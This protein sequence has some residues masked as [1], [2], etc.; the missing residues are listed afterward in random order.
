MHATHISPFSGTWY[1][2]SAAELELLLEECRAASAVR[3]GPYL[4]RDALGYV[5]PHAGP[6]YSGTV[7]SAV[8][9]SLL[10][11]NPERIV[12][13]AFTHRGGLHGIASPEVQRISTPLGEVA[14]DGNFAGGFPLVPESRLC[15]H[16]FEIQLPF[17]Q[18]AA[19]RSLLT[20]L[21]VGPMDAA[22]RRAAAERIASAW[23]PG[24][25]F[26]A[27]SDFTHYGRSFGYVP[28]PSNHSVAG[29]LHELDHDCIAAAGSLDSSLFL[30]T[31]NA[32][33]ATVCGTGPIALLL[34]VLRNL[35]NRA[36]YQFILDYQ[37]SGEITGDYRH[38]VSYA[39]LGYYPRSS[40]DLD[41]A[42]CDELLDAAEKT[43]D[44]LRRTGERR[45]VIAEGSPA[46]SALRGYFVS[47]HHGEELLGCVGDC[48][49]RTPLREGIGALTLAAALDDPRFQ[50]A[51]QRK[52]H[53]G[54][55]LSVLTPFR[56]VRDAGE[57]RIGRNGAVLRLGV[58]SGLL[59]PQVAHQRGWTVEDFCS[60]LARKSLLPPRAWCD[61][62]ARLEIFEA[63]VFSRP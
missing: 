46:L 6:V 57:L 47:L 35:A 2:E 40:F 49:G 26:L 30:E 28:F 39:S 41:A 27:S 5:V 1:P 53:I 52:G 23:R 12:L 13:L 19:P 38:S 42:D 9:R 20:P 11:Q 63:Q 43:L 25:V 44:G 54:I 32:R 24:V 4:F 60:A 34:D 59:L 33:D 51:A 36:V 58:H 48:I 21:Y 10:Q 56:R 62:Q 50:P 61:P 7:A 29:R 8:Y 16:S 15:D 17:L 37:A 22:E 3:T 31:V 55:E 18:K 14:I 45:A